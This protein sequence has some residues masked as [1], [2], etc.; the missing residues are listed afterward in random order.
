VT[1]GWSY[2]LSMMTAPT[3]WS[4]T[5]VV[6]HWLA[7]VR[8]RSSPACQSV[9]FYH[10]TNKDQVRVSTGRNKSIA[11]ISVACIIVNSEKPTTRIKNLSSPQTPKSPTLHRNRH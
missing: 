4:T 9:R 10:K 5:T 11:Y 3:V 8:M 6:A 7:V 1:F 2:Q